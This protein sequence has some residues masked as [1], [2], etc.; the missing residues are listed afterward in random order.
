M[1]CV[2]H[3]VS[4]GSILMNE[5]KRGKPHDSF[6]LKNTNTNT[7]SSRNPIEQNNDEVYLKM[8]SDSFQSM[9]VCSIVHWQNVAWFTPSSDLN[10]KSRDGNWRF[11]NEIIAFE[12]KFGR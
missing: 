9:N 3:I 12:P 6:T 10:E 4:D 5:W 1:L 11:M 7:N 2:S 8:I